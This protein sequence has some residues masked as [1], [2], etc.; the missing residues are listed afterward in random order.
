MVDG[1]EMAMKARG[2]SEQTMRS[3]RRLKCPVCDFEFSIIYARATAC[4]GC[5][6]S[7]RNCPMVRC[8]KC[9]T[10]FRIMDMKIVK[11]GKPIIRSKLQ[12][13]RLAT[14]MSRFLMYY[15]KQL[16]WKFGP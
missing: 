10:E 11:V 6:D 16:G 3:V 7:A 13:R 8:P 1:F 15:Y 2:F 5:R 9:D 4:L 12:E 14:H